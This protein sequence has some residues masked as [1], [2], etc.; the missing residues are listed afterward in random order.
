VQILVRPPPTVAPLYD[1]L[2]KKLLFKNVTEQGIEEIMSKLW[3]IFGLFK[4]SG[5]EQCRRT[6]ILYRRPGSFLWE[7]SLK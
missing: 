6:R 5:L 1:A 3:N 7:C 2:N 4:L